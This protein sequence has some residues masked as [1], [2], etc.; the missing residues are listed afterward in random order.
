[1]P[2]DEFERLCADVKWEWLADLGASVGRTRRSYSSSDQA[3]MYRDFRDSL[4][5]AAKYFWD[6][7]ALQAA[8][9]TALRRMDEMIY[10]D[11][12]QR[13]PRGE[14]KLSNLRR[15]SPER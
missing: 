5:A 4:E 13:P 11:E 10:E 6:D 8:L 2:S 14:A 15:R 9:S 7:D 12:D 1:M 3:G